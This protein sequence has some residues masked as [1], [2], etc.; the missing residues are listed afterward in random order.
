MMLVLAAWLHDLGP[1]LVRFT[2]SF[3]LRWYGLSYA[4]GFLIAWGVMQWLARRRVILLSPQRVTDALLICVMGV[5][6]GGRLGYVLFYDLPL[7]WSFGGGF[8]WWGVL[9][10]NKGGMASH[11][12]IIGVI[13]ACGFISLGRKDRDGVRRDRV[14][15][16]H[17]LDIVAFA[18]PIGLGLGRLANFINGELLGR[19]V[20][21][22]GQPAPWWAVKF[23]QELFELRQDEIAGREQQLLSLVP[24][25]GSL[26]DPR[27]H[28][29]VATLVARLQRGSTEAAARL[30]PVLYSRHP[31]QLYQAF[32]DGLVLSLVLWWVWRKPRKPGVVGA[33]FMAT[34]GVMRIATEFWRLPDAHLIVKRFAG[35]S[36]GQWLSV[37]MVMVGLI[38]LYLVQ[39]RKVEPIGGWAR[40]VQPSATKAQEQ[41]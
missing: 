11:G 25:A 41:A 21:Q 27:W 7:L 5:L 35:L 18:C 12:G 14:S 4:I 37:G 28:E 40:T 9:R 2:D 32:S 19:I 15:W 29:G 6:I 3:G 13:L 22:P 30:E 24:D 17:L 39:R 33:M 10:I 8:P 1:F 38:G 26:N 23:P 16:L 31:S 20:A 34:Y 36:R